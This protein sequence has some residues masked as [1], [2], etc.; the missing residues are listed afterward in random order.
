MSRIPRKLLQSL[1][2]SPFL[3]P[4]WK[5]VKA[6]LPPGSR[7][8]QWVYRLRA[9]SGLDTFGVWGDT[10]RSPVEEDVLA[11]AQWVREQG[12]QQVFL[13]VASTEL[14]EDEGQRST[15]LAL[16]LARRGIPCIFA[17]WRWDEKRWRPQDRLKDGVFQLP[18][19]V[20]ARWPD[21]V[22]RVFD[23]LERVV[24][25][26][27]PHPTLFAALAEANAAGWITLYDVVDD[28]REFQRVGQ[29]DWYEP[30]CEGHFL[31]AT[32]AVIAINQA[33]AE[34]LGAGLPHAIEVIPN[35]LEP[36]VATIDR[37]RSLARGQV[38]VGYFGYLSQAWFDWSLI[39]QAAEARPDWEFYLIGYGQEQ[40]IPLPAN[41]HLLGKKPRSAL[42]SYA[43]NW[44]VA[45][46]P[47]K[48]EPL[49]AGADPIKWYEYLAMGLPVVVTGVYPPL[50]AEG[51]IVRAN[52]LE[53]FLQALQSA[54]GS[55]ED[56]RNTRRLYA[57]A[58]TWTQRLS[59]LL[60]IVQSGSQRIAEKRALFGRRT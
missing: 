53:G 4:F 41:V 29:A 17:Y 3:A 38:T 16:E 30:L 15:N 48:D 35:G 47:F 57:A 42:A 26:E 54:V 9:R 19:D 51:L 1:R 49:A 44:D 11:F 59:D 6:M 22:L 32:D 18:V 27:F 23:G 45:V 28:W 39:Q 10:S 43:A 25:F 52:D 36:T 13:L 12:S 20:L 7:R 14:R 56:N 31:A 21:S 40:G 60:N 2:K 55:T 5:L 34:R 50:G 37:P 46:V 58:S 8:R 24:M 33:L